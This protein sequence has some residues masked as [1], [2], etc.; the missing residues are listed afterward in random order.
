MNAFT[1]LPP[2]MPFLAIGTYAAVRFARWLDHG[3]KA[4]AE[5]RKAHAWHKAVVAHERAQGIYTYDGAISDITIKHGYV[6]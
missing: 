3:S 1:L 2:A 6:T 5:R 4:A